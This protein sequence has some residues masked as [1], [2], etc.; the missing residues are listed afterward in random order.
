M[1]RSRRSGSLG[2]RAASQLATAEVMLLDADPGSDR[3]HDADRGC[4]S[5]PDTGGFRQRP[6]PHRLYRWAR[7]FSSL[8]KPFA[9]VRAFPPLATLATELGGRPG[10]PS[11]RPIRF[12]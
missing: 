10:K 2:L 3:A 8:P 7:V 6:A 11:R 12:G 5:A 9:S 1:F 4:R